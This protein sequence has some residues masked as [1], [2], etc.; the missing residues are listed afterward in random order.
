MHLLEILETLF[1][2]GENNQTLLSFLLLAKLIKVTH[3]CGIPLAHSHSGTGG[4][5]VHNNFDGKHP[6]TA[7]PTLPLQ[8]PH[9]FTFSQVN[10]IWPPHNHIGVSPYKHSE[11]NIRSIFG[12]VDSAFLKSFLET[13]VNRLC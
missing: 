11:Q 4:G 13:P 9:G 1:H 12:T 3:T 2:R 10:H 5:F 7:D 6:V 8:G